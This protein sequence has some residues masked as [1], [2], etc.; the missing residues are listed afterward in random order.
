M[1]NEVAPH[2][3]PSPTA[4]EG[5]NRVKLLFCFCTLEAFC[6]REGFI[7][8]ANILGGSSLAA[9]ITSELCWHGFSPTPTLRLWKDTGIC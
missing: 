9:V 2:V 3:L 4:R 5:L 7:S 6:C 8:W 1:K